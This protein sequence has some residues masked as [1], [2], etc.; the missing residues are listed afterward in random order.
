MIDKSIIAF[1][2]LL[3]VVGFLQWWTLKETNRTSRV[4]DRA[5]LYFGDPEIFPY[6]KSKPVTTGVSI[7]LMNVGNVPSRLISVRSGW[8]DN[9]DGVVD[10]FRLK[11]LS[12][13]NVAKFIGPKQGMRLQGH[14]V[15]IDIYMKATAMQANIFV[16]M[17][18]RYAD[19]FDNK[20]VR[21]TQTSRSLRFDKFGGTSWGFDYNCT[22]DDCS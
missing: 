13:V 1:T 10:Q 16:L 22:D 6:P 12:E 4:R 18:V 9:Q 11:K 15:P 8:T 17:E 7:V 21:V 14:E 3:V 20:K 2:F 5:Y 19:G